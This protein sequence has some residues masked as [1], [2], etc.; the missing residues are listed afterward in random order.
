MSFE[1]ALERQQISFKSSPT[2]QVIQSRQQR[3]AQGYRLGTGREN[4]PLLGKLLTQILPCDPRVTGPT[5]NPRLVG[6]ILHCPTQFLGQINQRLAGRESQTQTPQVLRRAGPRLTALRGTKC[7]EQQSESTGPR[8]KPEQTT[9]HVQVEQG[10]ENQRGVLIVHTPIVSFVV[11]LGR[12]AAND[13]DEVP[14][15]PRLLQL[16]DR[17]LVVLCF[18]RQEEL[19]CEILT[20][21]D[22]LGF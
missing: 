5:V 14:L 6:K 16:V 13:L 21:I 12:K 3:I 8:G 9:R 17:Q 4:R 11:T 10:V 19:H 7:P 1:I 18:C 20:P 22:I 2:S 15:L